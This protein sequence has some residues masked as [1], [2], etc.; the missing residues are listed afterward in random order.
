LPKAD[1]MTSRQRVQRCLEFAGPDRVP[2]DLWLLPIATLEHGPAAIAALQTR[3]P[4]DFAGPGV[5]NREVLALTEGDPYAV[6]QYRDEWGCV[7]ENVQAGVIG[8]V[9][10][11]ILED[12]S[13][14]DDLR[15]PVEALDVDIDAVNRACAATD[16]LVMA[17]CC[18]RPF[19]RAQFL[20]G[21]ANLL[22]DLA[23]E[24]PELA[25]LLRR[26][27]D[28]Y[29]RE[30]EVWSQTSV[31]AIGFM[32]DW[33]SQQ[34]L[35][36]APRQWRRLFKPLYADYVRIAHAAGKKAFMHSDGHIFAIYEDLIEIGVDAV[37]SQLFCMD[38]EEIGRR[39]AG[40][41]TFWGEIDR[42]HV[43]P[44]ES[45][46]VAREAVRRVVASLY[47]PAGGV[48]AQFEMGAGARLA[49]ADAVFQTWL[50]LT[51]AA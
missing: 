13:R 19:E 47:R 17:G 3:W 31:D 43:L 7:F 22:R 11:P 6:G 29:C 21:T 39:F 50:E 48:I 9:K 42:Q 40:R 16:K 35:L 20:R 38:I 2:R 51:G 33:G 27:H 28:L 12:W 49:N 32:D 25:E 18:P 34:S 45:P 36:I 4:G 46:D 24:P 41:I 10:H 14:L 15:L 44:A 5:V 23:K 1:L 26:I 8:Q 30:V 37:N